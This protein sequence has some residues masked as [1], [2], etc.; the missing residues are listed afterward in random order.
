MFKE[1]LKIIMNSMVDKIW[2]SKIDNQNLVKN[3][4]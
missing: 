4:R 1:N 3:N 2:K